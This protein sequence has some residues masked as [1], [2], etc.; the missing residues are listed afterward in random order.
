MIRHDSLGHRLRHRR[1]DGS[2]DHRRNGFEHGAGD[3]SHRLVM[4]VGATVRSSPDS[5][6]TIEA[7]VPD[8]GRIII[9]APW[10]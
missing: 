7:A 6:R 9:S 3:L 4:M 2:G 10:R 1:C 5:R 8:I